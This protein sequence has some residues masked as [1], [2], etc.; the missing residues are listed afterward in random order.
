MALSYK[1]KKKTVLVIGGSGGIGTEIVKKMT[2]TGA[3][4]L[5]PNE[6]ELNLQ[7]EASIKEAMQKILK[8]YANIDVII[9]S[10][11]LPLKNKHILDMG[12]KDFDAHIKLQARGFFNIFQNLKEQVKARHRTKFIVILTEYCIGKPPSGIADYVTAKYALMGLAK[13]MAVELAK[14]NCTVNMISPGMVNTGLMSFLPPKLIEIT[15]ESNPLKRL[16]STK[17]IADVVEFLASDKS[18]YLNGVNITVNGGGV[19]T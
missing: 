11:T 1:N 17:D 8:G 19:M 18:E 10:A 13:S 14:Y 3:K 5:S 15:A 16:A 7:N 9:F 2:S 4:V 6:R 12:W